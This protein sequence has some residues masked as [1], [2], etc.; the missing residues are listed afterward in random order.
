[1]AWFSSIAGKAE[2]LLNQLDEAAAT[3]LREAGVATPNKTQAPPTSS[4]PVEPDPVTRTGLSYE[5]VAQPLATPT[6]RRSQ[7]VASRPLVASSDVTPPTWN[8][9]DVPFSSSSPKVSH[10]FVGDGRGQK[11]KDDDSLLDFL[12]SPSLSEK[13][14]TPTSN[15]SEMRV[16]MKKKVTT[17][18]TDSAQS[19]SHDQ[20]HDPS[21]DKGWSEDLT[22]IDSVPILPLSDTTH[23]QA[24]PT[25]TPSIISYQ[26]SQQPNKNRSDQFPEVTKPVEQV[27]QVLTASQNQVEEE[28]MRLREEISY[29]SKEL[30]TN[31]IRNEEKG[32]GKRREKERDITFIYR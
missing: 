3:S 5:P 15:S 32:K 4:E 16:R 30:K 18:F 1:M 26:P 8:S 24:T 9:W 27:E 13:K 20:S 2:Q 10:S 25:S 6:S 7:P 22:K 11:A 31:K 23:L 28:N 21:H 29:L 19:T 17:D 12:N 14:T